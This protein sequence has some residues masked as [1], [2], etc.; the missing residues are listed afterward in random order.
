MYATRELIKVD[1]DSSTSSVGPFAQ[2]GTRILGEKTIGVSLLDP[3]ESTMTVRTGV[4]IGAGDPERMGRTI[5][6]GQRSLWRWFTLAAIVLIALEWF[7]Y[8]GKVKIN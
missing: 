8:A 6:Y 7:A 1:G 2:I 5:G 4:V 3:Q